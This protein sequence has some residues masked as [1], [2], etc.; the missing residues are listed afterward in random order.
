MSKT[1]RVVVGDW[2][3]EN[4]AILQKHGFDKSKDSRGRWSMYEMTREQLFELAGKFMDEG[5]G[6]M[7]RPPSTKTQVNW[8]YIL[9]VDSPRGRFSQR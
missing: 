7:I 3:H 9:Y 4:T 2:A 5:L 6:V 8:D 1:L